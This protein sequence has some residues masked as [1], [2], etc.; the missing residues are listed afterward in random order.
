MNIYKE[1][2]MGQSSPPK[3]GERNIEENT[4]AHD[5]T[6]KCEIGGRN[7]MQQAVH[8]PCTT[9]MPSENR[10]AIRMRSGQIIQKH[11]GLALIQELIDIFYC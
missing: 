3:S 9:S 2:F 1:T 8:K 6:D 11:I 5:V 7:Q 10:E 4:V